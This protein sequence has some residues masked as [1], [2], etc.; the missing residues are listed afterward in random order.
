MFL[1]NVLNQQRASYCESTI[2]TKNLYPR[3][4][5]TGDTAYNFTSAPATADLRSTDLGRSSCRPA[6][7]KPR[8]LSAGL[9]SSLSCYCP[10]HPW[11]SASYIKAHPMGGGAVL[12]MSHNGAC[13]SMATSTTRTTTTFRLFG[14]RQPPYEAPPERATTMSGERRGGVETCTS[15]DSGEQIAPD[16][17]KRAA[18]RCPGRAGGRDH[19][20]RRRARRRRGL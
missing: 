8:P 10:Q 18:K 11:C 17:E 7:R 1:A 12:A 6:P 14:T 19:R 15:V 20:A 13:R 4:G 3:L 2:D 16:A 9:L 5:N